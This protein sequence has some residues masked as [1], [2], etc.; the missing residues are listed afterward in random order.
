MFFVFFV[1]G[2]SLKHFYTDDIFRNRNTQHVNFTHLHEH[3]LKFKS[4]TNIINKI[5]I[6]TSLY[7][8]LAITKAF[9]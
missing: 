9:K 6:Y 5:S 3:H 2:S 7:F 8:Q 4:C 1:P